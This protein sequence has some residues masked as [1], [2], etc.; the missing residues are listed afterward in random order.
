MNKHSEYPIANELE[1]LAQRKQDEFEELSE[2]YSTIL[3]LINLFIEVNELDYDDTWNRANQRY[4]EDMT[5]TPND[6]C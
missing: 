2:K 6:G 5:Y 4:D 3:Q 1:E